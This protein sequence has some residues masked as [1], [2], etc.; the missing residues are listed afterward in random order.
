M[1]SANLQAC[2]AVGS[3]KCRSPHP[4]E[5]RSTSDSGLQSHG[6]SGNHPPIIPGIHTPR[7]LWPQGWEVRTV[8][9]E[10][11]TNICCGP[12]CVSCTV[13]HSGFLAV[14]PPKAHGKPREN[15][16]PRRRAPSSCLQWAGLPVTCR[17]HSPRQGMESGSARLRR[18]PAGLAAPQTPSSLSLAWQLRGQR[19]R[20]HAVWREPPAPFPE[21]ASCSCFLPGTD[22]GKQRTSPV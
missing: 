3:R 13:T 4:L 9:G 10:C 1:S 11:L 5:T 17:D 2:Q 19:V 22:P 8:P 7:R 21:C 20:P 15:A 6:G 12:C 18:C 16:A 14:N